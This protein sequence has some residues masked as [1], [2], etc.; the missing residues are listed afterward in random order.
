M[1][2][3]FSKSAIFPTEKKVTGTNRPEILESWVSPVP[4]SMDIMPMMNKIHFAICNRA[5]HNL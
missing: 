5:P 1:I 4:E 3:D 2:S